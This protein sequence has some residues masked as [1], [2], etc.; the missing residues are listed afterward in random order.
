[1]PLMKVR[2]AERRNHA[3]NLHEQQFLESQAFGGFAHQ[4]ATAAFAACGR[5]KHTLFFHVD[6]PL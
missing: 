1:M 2:D 5:I 6:R 3:F 4:T